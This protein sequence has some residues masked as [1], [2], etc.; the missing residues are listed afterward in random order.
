M[1]LEVC[2]IIHTLKTFR[3]LLLVLKGKTVY[4]RLQSN[5]NNKI[6]LLVDLLGLFMA[7]KS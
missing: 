5:I 7:I 4:N 3:D 2:T 1:Q 6:N